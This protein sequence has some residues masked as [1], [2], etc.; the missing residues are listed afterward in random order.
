MAKKPEVTMTRI[1]L[2]QPQEEVIVEPSMP[3]GRQ[4]AVLRGGPMRMVVAAVL[5]AGG[6]VEIDHETHTITI[7][8]TPK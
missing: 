1:K 7:T 4:Q 5:D 8:A 3:H 6:K 2:R